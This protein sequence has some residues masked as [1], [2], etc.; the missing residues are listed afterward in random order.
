VSSFLPQDDLFKKFRFPHK[1]AVLKWFFLTLQLFIIL[2]FLAGLLHVRLVKSF[3][4]WRRELPKGNK[5]LIV[6][7]KEADSLGNHK[8]VNKDLKRRWFQRQ[9]SMS[10]MGAV[11]SIMRDISRVIPRGTWLEKI[12]F[13]SDSIFIV[14]RTLSDREVLR[15]YASLSDLDILDGSC[16]KY[17]HDGDSIKFEITANRVKVL[18]RATS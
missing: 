1:G 10:E 13:L 15:F 3:D 12:S 8:K 14:G 9:V 7:Q 5:E 16:L 4:F 6:I 11:V 18:P 17:N 2:G